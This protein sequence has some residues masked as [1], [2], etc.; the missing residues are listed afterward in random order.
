MSGNQNDRLTVAMETSSRVGSIAIGSGDECLLE[1]TFSGPM[2]HATELVPALQERL[3]SLGRRPA[4]IKEIIVS[5]GP[6]SFTGVRISVMV[7]R[8]LSQVLGCKLIAVPT[9]EVLALNAPVG[10]APNIGVVLDARR[11]MIF[12]ACYRVNHTQP[13]T[14]PELQVIMEPTLG[15]P[16]TLPTSWPQPI[17]LLGEGIEYH[18]AALFAAGF[19][20]RLL[21][22]ETA[23]PR[24]SALYQVGRR[25]AARGHF[26]LREALLPLYLR[27]PEAQELWEKR[28][29]QSSGMKEKQES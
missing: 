22:A 26:V 27:K 2:Q 15:S 17:Q 20:D 10:S 16:K 14:W 7:A 21:P 9:T 4:D 25:R 24:A 29:G 5:V 8:T 11:G 3:F 19:D 1:H 12:G 18:R 13:A 28:Q 6:G 23:V